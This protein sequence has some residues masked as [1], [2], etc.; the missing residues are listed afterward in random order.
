[1]ATTRRKRKR[2]RKPQ[3]IK[4]SIGN[5]M[6]K[7]KFLYT[8]NRNVESYSHYGKEYGCFSKN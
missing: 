8:V 3:K 7:L 5:D 1:M 2:K 6:E 4:A